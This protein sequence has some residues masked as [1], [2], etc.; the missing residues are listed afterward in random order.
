M[1]KIFHCIQILI[2]TYDWEVTVEQQ[3]M[4]FSHMFN[5]LFTVVSNY[6]VY[7][8]TDVL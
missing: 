4:I 8:R 7:R 1:D 5:I 6:G 3:N 2:F